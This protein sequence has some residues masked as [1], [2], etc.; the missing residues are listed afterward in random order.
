LDIPTFM[1]QSSVPPGMEGDFYANADT[2][3]HYPPHQSVFKRAG[4]THVPHGQQHISASTHR[5]FGEQIAAYIAGARA[6]QP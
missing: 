6:Q 4:N 3:Y 5:I 1:G 2:F